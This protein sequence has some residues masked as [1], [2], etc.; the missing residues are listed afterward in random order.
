M[1]EKSRRS[2]RASDLGKS[3][4]VENNDMNILNKNGL[5]DLIEERLSPRKKEKEKHGEVFTALWL[6][7]KMVNKLPKEILQNPNVKILGQSVGIG[8]FQ[9]SLYYKFMESLKNKIPNDSK[10]RKHI[11]ENILYMVEFNQDNIKVLENIFN[12]D[13]E[14]KLN[15]ICGDYL[16]LDTLKKFGIQT[17]FDVI[18]EN[19][20]YNKSSTGTGSYIWDKFIVK[21][22]SE[23]KPGGYLNLITPPAWRKPE[24]ERSRNKGLLHLMTKENQMIYLEMYDLEDGKKIFDAGTRFDIYLIQKMTSNTRPRHSTRVIDTKSIL[25]EI[26]LY[27]YKFIPN[28]SIQQVFKLIVKGNQP[29]AEV[30]F[31]AKYHASNKSIVNETKTK[32]YKY[33]IIKSIHKDGPIIYYSSSNER[34]LFGV[35]KVM[36]CESGINE[37]IIDIDG[38]YGQTQSMISL[39]ISSLEQGKEIVRFLKSKEFENVLDACSW[40]IFR[41][42][43]RMF[44]NFRNDFYKI[45]IGNKKSDETQVTTS[46]MGDNET[47][48]SPRKSPTTVHVRKSPRSKFTQENINL[49]TRHTSNSDTTETTRRQSHQKSPKKILHNSPT[50]IQ[51]RKSHSRILE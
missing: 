24:S 21:G 34:G 2:V 3:E 20:P 16:E 49:K 29:K 37:P 40:S 42:E 38:K 51:L 17:G 5:M 48:Y 9:V 41:I 27:D 4:D 43:W 44:D 30:I 25:Y 28:H 35:P 13:G 18:I 47:R 12:P 14:Y 10:R 50:K 8:N 6:C 19:P 15:I 11:L 31:T 7:D 32:E 1:K 46:R 22:M 45:N 26:D 39:K 36:F 23:L 33:P